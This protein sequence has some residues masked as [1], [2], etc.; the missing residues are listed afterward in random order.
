MRCNEFLARY[1]LLTDRLEYCKG[2]YL[3]FLAVGHVTD[4]FKKIAE[5]KIPLGL[6]NMSAMKK[7][8]LV[9]SDL[10]LKAKQGAGTKWLGNVVCPEEISQYYALSGCRLLQE[11]MYAVQKHATCLYMS[12]SWLLTFSTVQLIEHAML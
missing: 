7:R 12:A 3:H 4:Q 8:H 1:V 11:Y 2:I 9:S 10:W 6:R 5:K